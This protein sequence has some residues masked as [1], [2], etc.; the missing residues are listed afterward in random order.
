MRML[1]LCGGVRV[2]VVAAEWCDAFGVVTRGRVQL[3]LPDG[4]PGPVLGRDAGWWRSGHSDR[5]PIT[6]ALTNTGTEDE[7]RARQDQR[8][9][10]RSA[11]EERRCQERKKE[12]RGREAGKW[13]CPS[14]KIAIALVRLRRLRRWELRAV[15]DGFGERLLVGRPRNVA[16]K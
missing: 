8:R 16:E 11:Q 2:V 3:E 7:Y 13:E 5:Q 14:C 4:E 15:V 1:A 10:E 9:Q 12:L 6:D